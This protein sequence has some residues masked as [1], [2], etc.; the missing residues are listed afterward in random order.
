MNYRINKNILITVALCL[1]HPCYADSLSTDTPTDNSIEAFRARAQNPLSPHYSIPLK[2]VY[3]DADNGS[4]SIGSIQPIIPISLGTWNMINQ[5]SLNFIGTSGGVYGIAAL[6][7]PYSGSGA[8]G[9]GDT[10]FT[11]LFSPVSSD[12][13]SWGIGPTFAFPTDTLFSDINDRRSRQLGSGKFSIGPSVMFVTQAKSWTLGLNSK[14]IWSVLGN[15]SRSS[16]SQME[17]K[18]FVN[19]NL[20]EGWYLV[21]DMDMIA[22]WNHANNQQWTVPIGGGVGKVFDIGKHKLN[23]RLESYYNIVRPNQAPDWSVGLT[24]QLLL[25]E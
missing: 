17:L 15:H 21:S 2:Y 14:Q 13:F 8:T 20:S 16:V 4:V 24:V 19:Y 3:H 9:L 23:T 22:N 25:P 18:P 6:P 1:T 12:N 7:E 10:S 5:L 11:S